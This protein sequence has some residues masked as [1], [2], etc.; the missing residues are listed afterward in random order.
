MGFGK[1][2]NLEDLYMRVNRLTGPLP[3]TLL[4]ISTLK[5]LIFS[6]NMLTGNLPRE[7]GNMKAL[8]TLHL[9]NNMLSGNIPAELFMSNIVTI[10]ILFNFLNGSIP[11]DIERA[12]NLTY[13]NLA[14]NHL[15]GLQVLHLKENRL[16][17]LIPSTIMEGC[18]LDSLNLNS[19]QFEGT[20][21]R[22][23]EN[24]RQL[25]V[26]DVGNNKIKDVFPFWMETLLELRVLV[27]RSNR[28]NGII[29]LPSKSNSSFP[30]L[31]VFDIAQNSFTGSLPVRYLNN[32]RAMINATENMTDNGW[33]QKYDESMTFIFK[34]LELQVDRILTTLTTIDMS[35]N[36]FSGSIPEILGKLDSLRY[37]N[38]SYNELTGHI[39]S[40]LGNMT[41]LESL[42]LSTNQ[43]HGEIPRQLTRL[44]FLTKLNLSMNNLEGQIP[45]SHQFS[46]F[47]NDSYIGNQRLCGFPLTKKCV[48]GQNPVSLPPQEDDD[49]LVFLKDLRG[50]LLPWDMGVGF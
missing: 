48:E 9:T 15:S 35:E 37:L 19:N 20:L 29:L 25:Q 22:S 47:D 3:L 42:D 24:C 1:L 43:L 4:N 41:L 49:E 17:G 36:N 26:I 10:Q 45:Q 14:G 13:P 30:K 18:A 8:Q 2:K 50:K 23:L 11:L 44:T 34:G 28:F 46:T 40:S 16:H 27:L 5:S 31:Q 39:P 6:N 33:F 7:V 32:F 21:P 12:Q 38:L